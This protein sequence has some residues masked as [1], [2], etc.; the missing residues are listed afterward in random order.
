MCVFG[1]KDGR[2]NPPGECEGGELERRPSRAL[3]RWIDVGDCHGSSQPLRRARRRRRR[4]KVRP[5][6]FESE[7]MDSSF[8]ANPL[9]AGVGW[10]KKTR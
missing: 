7:E 1:S 5:D 4:E 10:M 2:L 3:R 6:A 8:R 9:S